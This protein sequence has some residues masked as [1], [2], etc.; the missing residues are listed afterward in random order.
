MHT[1]AG[2]ATGAAV[3]ALARQNAK[4]NARKCAVSP[5][6]GTLA[7]RGAGRTGPGTQKPSIRHQG[8]PLTMAT[9]KK[10]AGK[11]APGKAAGKAPSTAIKPVTEVLSKSS[12][13]NHLA[14]S[15]GVDNKGVRAVLEALERAMAG[16]VHKK[17]AGQFVLPGVLKVTSQAVAAKPK[18]KGIDPFT[19]QERWF[20]AKPASVKLKVR[21]LKK[22]KDA[23]L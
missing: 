2:R 18:R 8:I 20:E 14:A 1:C 7:G 23:A 13:I 4:K 15:S 3:R 6:A 12:L 11:A 16:A 21:A 17:G 10:S 9:T 22:L 5:K 19:K